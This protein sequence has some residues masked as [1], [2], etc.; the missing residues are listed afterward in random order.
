MKLIML[1]LSLFVASSPAIVVDVGVFDF[2]F[3]PETVAVAPGDTIRWINYGAFSHNTVSGRPDSAPGQLWSSPFLATGDTYRLPVT[4]S[5]PVPYYCSLHSQSM[6]GLLS[7]TTGIGGR[8]GNLAGPRLT[9]PS[10]NPT[11]LTIELP[12][13]LPVSI[14]VYDAI[15]RLRLGL[16]DRAPLPA[17]Q[18]RVGLNPAT[19][20]EGVYILSVA[21][22][23]WS[24][25]A[26]LVIVR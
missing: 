4:F 5:E 19:L 16:L 2:R 10:L 12:A 15:G 7:V 3:T 13:P 25:A 24:R 26:R 8:P 6:R 23:E 20:E 11:A 17:G 14:G 1:A 21:A 9:V 22:G 18:H